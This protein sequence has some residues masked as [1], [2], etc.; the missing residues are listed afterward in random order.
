D[1]DIVESKEI[2]KPVLKHHWESTLSSSDEEA[3]ESTPAM[4]SD[5]L[6]LIEE[7]EPMKTNDLDRPDIVLKTSGEEDKNTPE[8]ESA[9]SQVLHQKVK[10]GDTLYSLSRKYGITV[11]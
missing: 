6:P 3:E 8:Q 4:E 11:S 10:K 2:S 5:P 7:A 9:S 1:V